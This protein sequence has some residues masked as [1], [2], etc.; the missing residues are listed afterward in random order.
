[1][2]ILYLTDEEA[3]PFLVAVAE[4]NENKKIAFIH[5]PSAG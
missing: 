2:N 3:M 4:Q 5:M 1:V